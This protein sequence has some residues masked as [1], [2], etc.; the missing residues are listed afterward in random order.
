MICSLLCVIDCMNLSSVSSALHFLFIFTWGLLNF[1]WSIDM[2]IWFSLSSWFSPSSEKNGKII[3]KINMILLKMKIFNHQ[4]QQAR[5]QSAGDHLCQG[6][7]LA[8]LHRCMAALALRPFASWVI[9]WKHHWGSSTF[10]LILL[11][12][13]IQISENFKFNMQM[14]NIKPDKCISL[15]IIAQSFSLAN[16]FYLF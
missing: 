4:I 8:L 2:I 1:D 12:Q 9:S 5:Y 16:Y 13:Q 14:Q 11:L 10:S 3:L 15:P 6:W 7:S